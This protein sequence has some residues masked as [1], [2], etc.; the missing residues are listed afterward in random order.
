MQCKRHDNL[1][2]HFTRVSRIAIIIL[3]YN[4]RV[5]N[6]EIHHT[7]KNTLS[8][9][10][11]TLLAA[12]RSARPRDNIKLMAVY[13][14]QYHTTGMGRYT[15]CYSTCPSI[16]PSAGCQLLRIPGLQG[17]GTLLLLSAQ[18]STLPYSSWACVWLDCV[19]VFTRAFQFA[20][21]IDYI[22]FVVR[23]DSFCK[24]KIGLSIH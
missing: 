16:H 9:G 17:K 22:R 2:A 21:R 3:L 8:P 7:L 10:L 5:K 23:I 11:I 6:W 24:K 18:A 14:C 12:S 15:E 19:G 4:L 20:I 13:V 1:F